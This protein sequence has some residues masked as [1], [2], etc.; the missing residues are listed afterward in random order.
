MKVSFTQIYIQAGASFPFSAAFQRALREKFEAAAVP[1]E[2]FLKRYGSDWSVH[3]WI[4]AKRDIHATEI[5]GPSTSR[6]RKSQEWTLFLPSSVLSKRNDPNRAACAEVVGCACAVLD[7]I[8]VSTGTLALHQD[9]L[10]SDLV[11]DSA[12]FANDE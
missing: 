8:G 1:S 10:S 12:H 2:A 4:S 9:E 11:L 3:F 7:K 6:K 5:C